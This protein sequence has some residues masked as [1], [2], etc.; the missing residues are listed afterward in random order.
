MS[1]LKRTAKNTHSM[2]GVDDMDN[3]VE[4]EKT[5]TTSTPITMSGIGAAVGSRPSFASIL[6][7]GA[8]VAYTRPWHRIERGLRLNRIRI[9]VEELAIQFEMSADEKEGCFVYLQKALDKKLLNTLKI[10]NYDQD[11]QRIIAIKGLELKRNGEGVL[12]WLLS[13][14]KKNETRKKRV[15]EDEKK[16]ADM[17]T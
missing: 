2:G 17:S 8:R 9:F 16:D 3:G 11:T 15:V 10:V 5:P 1:G 14:K 4:D 13:M 12:R 7:E 6:E